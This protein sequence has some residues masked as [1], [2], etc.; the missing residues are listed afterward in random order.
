[1]GSQKVS[2]HTSS[3]WMNKEARSQQVRLMKNREDTHRLLQ[4]KQI[5]RDGLQFL[6]MNKYSL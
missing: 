2:L 3:Q 1:M 4:L 6:R 5:E